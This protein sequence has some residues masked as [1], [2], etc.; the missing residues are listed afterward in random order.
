M[1]M[2]MMMMMMR[3]QVMIKYL[4]MYIIITEYVCHVMMLLNNRYITYYFH[5]ITGMI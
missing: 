1:L 4:A 3:G 2:I 5:I